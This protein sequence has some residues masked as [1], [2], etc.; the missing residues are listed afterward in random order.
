MVDTTN[1][2]LRWRSRVRNNNPRSQGPTYRRRKD[3]TGRRDS[4]VRR[5]VLDVQLLAQYLQDE[6]W[7]LP[8]LLA[9]IL[10]VIRSIGK[11]GK[12]NFE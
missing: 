7:R 3:S 12:R 11:R 6:E 1:R 5:D 10:S 8:F 9:T 4:L 2:D